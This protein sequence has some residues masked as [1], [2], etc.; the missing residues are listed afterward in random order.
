M[1]I[2]N[3]YVRVVDSCGHEIAKDITKAC[4]S[5]TCGCLKVTSRSRKGQTRARPHGL[6]A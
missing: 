4:A 6:Q 2:K 3:A 1:S 5:H